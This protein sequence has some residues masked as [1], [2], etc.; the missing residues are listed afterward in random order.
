MYS[1]EL[2]MTE[3]YVY[4]KPPSDCCSIYVN[5]HVGNRV[6]TY[7]TSQITMHTAWG[8]IEGELFKY[9]NKR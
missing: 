8:E 3:V 1:N 4:S 5:T 9:N 7:Q 6:V 2:H